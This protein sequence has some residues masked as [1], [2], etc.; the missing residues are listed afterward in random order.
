[1][2]CIIVS[3][4]YF[5]RIPY[6]E[7]T[8]MQRKLF[9]NQIK[10]DN[11][12]NIGQGVRLEI[13]GGKRGV[14]IQYDN[15]CEVR[16]V[17][18]SDTPAKRIFIVDL[19]EYKVNQTKLA[20]ALS[21]S[22]QTIHNYVERKE[23]YG[24]EG[25]INSYNVTSGTNRRQQ[26]K[27]NRSKLPTGNINQKLAAKR[28]KERAKRKKDQPVQ[29]QLPFKIEKDKNLK[30]ISVE[31]QPFTEVHN[32]QENRYAGVF[33]Y[34]IHLFSRANLLTLLGGYFG[35][36]YK[37]FMIFILMVSSNVRSLEQLK[38]IRKREA[39]MILGIVRIPSKPKVWEWFYRAAHL[40]VG[41]KILD[42][43]FR[44][45][46]RTG[47]V[48]GHFL[49][50]DGHLLPYS[51]KERIR[52]AFSTQ[53]SIPLPG[54]TN[55]VTC[56]AT[57][58]IIDFDIQ[59]GTGDLRG[60]IS[61][62]SDKW[63]ED[64]PG[65][66]IHVFD[67][68]GYGADFFYGLREKNIC[69]VTWD[70]Y[71]NQSK[72]SKIPDSHFT[73]E[74][75]FNGKL[76]KYFEQ[77]K[78]FTVSKADSSKE[79]FPL[80]HLIIWN[81]KAN[82]RTA[83][84]AHTGDYNISSRDC[85]SG[86]L[87]RWGASENTFK[88]MKDRHPYHYHPGFKLIKSD[89]QD[90]ANPILKDLK[91]VVIT[92]KKNISSLKVKLFGIKPVFNKD[93][94]ERQN[95]RHANLIKKISEKGVILE[96]LR[97]DIKNEPARVNPSDI[98]DYREYKRVD[99]EGKKLFDLVTSCVWNARKEMVDWLRPYWKQENEVVDLFYA[100]T[101]CHGWVKS[102]KEE[103]RVRLEPLEQPS[104]RA[105]QEQLCRKLTYLAARLPNGKQMV[106]EVGN[107]PR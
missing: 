3:S 14:A 78:Q 79:T 89:K 60:H 49:F 45:Q 19:V 80:R 103:V 31:E 43:F 93:G 97:K 7:E 9:K 75:E 73:E 82:R 102:T 64:I 32:W 68:E 11:K 77:I 40:K 83:G 6:D 55:M 90:I 34:L 76:Y 36:M 24:L 51:G 74:I 48:G 18:L 61:N 59:E 41:Q 26:R 54:Q 106:L 70:K 104:R 46:M 96:Q 42:D 16:R 92:L 95:G 5:R 20:K 98:E 22:R 23:V 107:A 35:N 21:I 39:G 87:N 38:N 105:A 81:T 62:L 8:T 52:C 53:R 13:R 71:V 27:E 65:K 99:N 1:M 94:S 44:Y 25:L 58:R 37:I 56:D 63:S 69:F 66:T 2:Y 86:I 88:H 30:Q 10:E 29:S 67:R 100:I 4:W 17:D 33:I 91:K 57:G 84:L 15:S 50:T 47:Q 28:E 72:L 101:A 85:M 12:I